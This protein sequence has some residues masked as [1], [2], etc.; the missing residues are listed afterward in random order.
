M[1]IAKLV[2]RAERGVVASPLAIVVPPFAA[3]SG[4]L[5]GAEVA[6]VSSL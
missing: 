1:F 5:P 3:G 2:R 4:A 6:V